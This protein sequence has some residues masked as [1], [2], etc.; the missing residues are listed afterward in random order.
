MNNTFSI[1]MFGLMVGVCIRFIYKGRCIPLPDNK[2]QKGS[3][4]GLE[5]GAAGFVIG[6]FLGAILPDVIYCDAFLK[7]EGATIGVM[8]LL[9]MAFSVI[10]A[11]C[12]LLIYGY[13]DKRA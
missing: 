3:A 12:A 7:N 1:T 10:G 11:I 13:L 5:G 2:T 6:L 8:I 4:V 9:A